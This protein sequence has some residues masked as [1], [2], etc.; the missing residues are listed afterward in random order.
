MGVIVLS[1]HQPVVELTLVSC[2]FRPEESHGCF[3]VSSPKGN[4]DD[5]RVDCMLRAHSRRRVARLEGMMTPSRSSQISG[6][7]F[8]L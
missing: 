8:G 1:Q 5:P 7:P 3:E 2:N 6:R 4:P